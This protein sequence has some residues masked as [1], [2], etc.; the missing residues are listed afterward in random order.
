MFSKHSC[1]TKATV[2]TFLDYQD[3]FDIFPVTSDEWDSLV[4]DL[5]VHSDK[6]P[7]A[8]ASGPCTTAAPPVKPT[9]QLYGSCV[10]DRVCLEFPELGGD[11]QCGKVCSPPIREP[12]SPVTT[13]APPD[14]RV[15]F[16]CQLDEALY[17]IFSTIL[18]FYLV[19]MLAGCVVA[20]FGMVGNWTPFDPAPIYQ[21][22]PGTVI[23]DPTRLGVNET[24]RAASMKQQADLAEDPKCTNCYQCRLPSLGFWLGCGICT[25][26]SYWAINMIDYVITVVSAKKEMCL[27]V[28]PYSYDNL[29]GLPMDFGSVF[30]LWYDSGN[31]YMFDYT[32]E[33][34]PWRLLPLIFV[35]WFTV[36]YV[37]WYAMWTQNAEEVV[38][39][40][41]DRIEASNYG[42][43]EASGA[44]GG[45]GGAPVP[46][47]I[48]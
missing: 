5:P 19:K 42:H 6:T 34:C 14:S 33:I 18:T 23:Q 20:G 8:P 40:L 24:F 28:L 45:A 17:A 16:D 32:N 3:R 46:C 38:T 9:N 30:S 27:K 11:N 35:T 25:V 29:T 39:T 43:A 36:W 22:V 26:F 10:I 48:Q 7:P 12:I 15:C 13:T 31:N 47:S 41:T 4:K 2:F 37:F 44:G 21:R 1:F